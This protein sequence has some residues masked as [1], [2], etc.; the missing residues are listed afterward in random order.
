MC[1]ADVEN[2]S[3][4]SGCRNNVGSEGQLSAIWGHHRVVSGNREV[5][6]LTSLLKTDH[7]LDVCVITLVKKN[8]SNHFKEMFFETLILTLRSL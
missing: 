3:A 8:T 5:M 2:E 4:R 6:D 1:P 7:S